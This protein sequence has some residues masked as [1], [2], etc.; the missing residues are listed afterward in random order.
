MRNKSNAQAKLFRFIEGLS[1]CKILQRLSNIW[2][3]IIGWL[4]ACEDGFKTVE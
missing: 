4:K 3:W 1:N 2:A